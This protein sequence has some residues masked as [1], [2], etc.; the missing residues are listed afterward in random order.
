MGAVD[1]DSV[2]LLK[3]IQLERHDVVELLLQSGVCEDEDGKVAV[4][5]S[6]ISLGIKPIAVNWSQR[7]LNTVSEEWFFDAAYCINFHIGHR[8]DTDLGLKL[9]VFTSINLSANNLETVP[10]MI[11][12][13]PSLRF[14][15]LS[16]NKLSALPSTSSETD[17]FEMMSITDNWNSPTLEELELQNN[18]L[19]QVPKVLF[20]MPMLHSINLTN[21]KLTTLPF[22]MW[23][24][25][26]LKVLLVENNCLTYLPYS[27]E[28]V[29]NRPVTSSV[30][31]ER[32]PA[33]SLPSVVGLS[34]NGKKLDPLQSMHV[35]SKRPTW[36]GN[37]DDDE[38]DEDVHYLNKS[39]LNKLDL[40]GNRFTMLPVGLPCLAQNLSRLILKKNKITEVDSITLLPY[41][42]T[43][44][45]LSGNGLRKFDL[46]EQKQKTEDVCFAIVRKQMSTRPL[47]YPAVRAKFCTHCRHRQLS[48]LTHLVL[49]DNNLD[50][51]PLS[52]RVVK[53]F[54]ESAQ[55]ILFPNLKT[56]D[57]GKNRLSSVPT[58]IGKLNRL[59][60]ISLENNPNIDVLPSELGLCS[61]LYELKIDQSNIKDP[62]RN[63]MEKQTLDGRRDIRFLT[64]YLR[65]LHDKAQ[66]YP[67]MKLMVVGVHGIG[68]TSLLNALR[69]D[70]SGSYQHGDHKGTFNERRIDE[71]IGRPKSASINST[72]GVDICDWQYQRRF[73]RVIKFSTWDFGGQ[74]EYYATHQCFLSRRAVYLLLWKLTDG[75]E[76]VKQLEHWLLNIQERAPNSSVIIVGTYLDE[77]VK[78]YS[79]EYLVEM[80]DEIKR[81]YVLSKMGGWKP[82]EK[83]L[84]NIVDIVEV[85]CKTDTNISKLRELIYDTVANL[86]ADGKDGHMN[87][88]DKKIPASYI[89]VEKAV[90]T[91]AANLRH[92][93]PVLEEKKFRKQVFELLKIDGT[94]LRNGDE[95]LDQ[96]VQFL[97]DYGILLHYDDPALRDLYFVD[98][99]WLCDM[100]AHVVTVRS[101]NPFIKNGV[102]KISD[103]QNQIFH[104]EKR[105]PSSMVMKYVN[106]MSKFEVAIKISDKFLLIPSLLPDKQK[107]CAVVCDIE[108]SELRKAMNIHAYLNHDVYRRQ[109]LMSYTPSGFWARLLARLI[110]DDRIC[111]IVSSCCEIQGCGDMESDQ[112]WADRDTLMRAAPPEWACWKTGIELSCFGTKLLRVCQL[113][114]DEPFYG[115]NSSPRPGGGGVY[116]KS[117]TWDASQ[118]MVPVEILAPNVTIKIEKFIQYRDGGDGESVVG[119]RVVG[120]GEVCWNVFYLGEIKMCS[121][122]P[123]MLNV[124]GLIYIL[125]VKKTHHF[126]RTTIFI[127][128]PFH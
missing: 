76:G 94:E 78:K 45:D 110:A 118:K 5:A 10:I 81:R 82:S 88:L 71:K 7:N 56:L 68:K 117:L 89:A 12:Q 104:G 26:R 58:F 111:K 124:F 1:V 116:V 101:V 103:L 39:G 16:E 52:Q 48:D 120:V 126:C 77:V 63:I 113:D 42:L 43:T 92:E 31:K 47:S 57:L 19:T 85:S 122:R 2:G 75:I 83:G 40:S 29:R 46:S 91:L 87:L 114:P 74:T 55:K 125:R 86:K 13:L 107:E 84:P 27:N 9:K 128:F 15:Y 112:A 41:S 106:L 73:Q 108:S 98:P 60:S 64:G 66:A 36:D 53:G 119:F 14:L 70:G 61:E 51:L 80:R 72:V 3:A 54:I 34:E 38:D 79:R 97:H 99:Q 18:E 4:A 121:D 50:N 35:Y 28:E 17:D 115:G 25:P 37:E 22:D 62:P 95:E 109:Y 65:S 90:T 100:L 59:C 6:E 11:F 67:N 69:K 93:M 30:R 24:A 127:L 105:F 8:L 32:I 102:L 123:N 33:S 20:Q 21:N 44:L 96:A 49:S 23:A